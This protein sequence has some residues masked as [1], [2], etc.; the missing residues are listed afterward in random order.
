MRSLVYNIQPYS[1]IGDNATLLY[2][3]MEAAG[4]GRTYL[5]DTRFGGILRADGGISTWPN[6]I[7]I[8]NTSDG[9]PYILAMR[10]GYSLDDKDQ[11]LR[12]DGS[13]PLTGDWNVGSK[14]ITGIETAEA[15]TVKA[16]TGIFGT[17]LDNVDAALKATTAY[18]S[19]AVNMANTLTVGGR[20]NLNGGLGVTGSSDLN[21]NLNVIGP[22]ALTGNLSVTGS[23][24][25]NGGLGVTGA[26]NLNGRLNVSG[27]T[28]LAGG[29]KVADF[30]LENEALFGGRCNPS[31]QT[32]ARASSGSADYGNSL[33]LLVCDPNSST[34]TRPQADYQSQIQ[35]LAGN[36]SNVS[37]S[38]DTLAN[39]TEQL[40]N[41]K[42]YAEYVDIMWNPA[43]FQGTEIYKLPQKDQF[44]NI[45]KDKNG[46]PVLVSYTREVWKSDLWYSDYGGRTWKPTPWVCNPTDRD[47]REARNSNSFNY[48][49]SGPFYPPMTPPM[50]FSLDGGADA[51]Q[52]IVY[53]VGCIDRYNS[54]FNPPVWHVAVGQKQRNISGGNNC[55][56]GLGS[57]LDEFA[58]L[59][60]QASNGFLYYD[61][62]QKCKV[63]NIRTP[64]FNSEELKARFMVFFK[65]E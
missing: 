57:N 26:S 18:F 51:G 63:F 19:E 49:G 6:P 56:S 4:G 62:P 2:R 23:G 37:S 58:W 59:T 33:R 60:N 9:P 55:G 8:R 21:G 29:T 1:N 32:L 50:I 42:V 35:T 16:S 52:T 41:R 64:N 25:I 30:R 14:S 39:L 45:V 11:F 47:T 46:A 48:A 28:V 10:N 44:G 20:T 12:K 7:K 17:F 38:V 40:K 13:T 43:T 15:K 34:W 65:K 36:L 27:D 3:V 24:S 31:T 54:I 5:S 53:D 61:N 22:S